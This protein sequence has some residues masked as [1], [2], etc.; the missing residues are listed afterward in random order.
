MLKQ[1]SLII[2]IVATLV[3]ATCSSSP[4]PAAP[5]EQLPPPRALSELSVQEKSAIQSINKFGWKLFQSIYSTTDADDN[6]FF[7][8]LSVSYA[9][10]LALNGAS[11]SNS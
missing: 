7:S 3:V 9:L 4:Q 1:F 2:F 5:E 8:P 11:R 6:I 10:G